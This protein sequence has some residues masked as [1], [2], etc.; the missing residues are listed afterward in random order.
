MPHT[1]KRAKVI[2]TF[3]KGS[4]SDIGN[5]RPISLFSIPSKILE[6][7]VCDILDDHLRKHSLKNPAQWGFA[8][9]LSAEGMLLS[10]T[11]RWKMELDKGLTVGAIFVDFRKAFDS[12][13]HNILLLKLQA[14]DICGNLHEW[15]MN[16]LS[17]RCQC[18]LCLLYTSDAAD[19]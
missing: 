2:P 5:Y 1:W 8:K 10:L 7:Q 11:D 14:V 9:G 6:H 12:L 17:D 18:T 3:N 15:L 19:E 13:S 4:K 16:Y